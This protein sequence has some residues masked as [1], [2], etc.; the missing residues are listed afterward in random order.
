MKARWPF[1]TLLLAFPLAFAFFL[2]EA[3]LG[4]KRAARALAIPPAPA[5][6]AVES[7]A[8]IS[9][10]DP[11]RPIG[12]ISGDSTPSP[13]TVAVT[14]PAPIENRK[15][16]IENTAPALLS[17]TFTRE[18]NSLIYDADTRLRLA[19][20]L[21]LSSPTGVMVSNEKQTI[22]AGDMQIEA[23]KNTIT[24]HEGILDTN[25]NQMKATVASIAFTNENNQLIRMTGENVTL[26]LP[27]GD[28]EN[29][30]QMA[31]DSLRIETTNGKF[32]GAIKS[33]DA[34]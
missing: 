4:G 14:P 32:S 18:E 1:I 8:N 22:F 11:I 15:S 6:A 20:D 29:P 10:I 19:S 9:P 3:G 7:S 13:A 2:S 5:T 25:T 34:K 24:A 12:P 27:T 30:Q 33:G 16:K 26:E 23:G 21:T 28:Q 31:S 17:G